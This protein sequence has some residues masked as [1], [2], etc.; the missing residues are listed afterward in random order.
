MVSLWWLLTLRK[1]SAVLHGLRGSAPGVVELRQESPH[2]PRARV[3]GRE[4][5][6]ED[7][8]SSEEPGFRFVVPA[9]GGEKP[10]VSAR[11]LC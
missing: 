9:H 4:V 8:K 1:L 7:F 2:A 3:V 6:L 10:P 5:T 11:H